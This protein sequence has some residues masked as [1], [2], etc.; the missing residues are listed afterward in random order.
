MSAR[1]SAQDGR[2][3]AVKP[4]AH[5]PR[6]RDSFNPVS[7]TLDSYLNETQEQT[8]ASG[9]KN[10]PNDTILPLDS[11]RF[12]PSPHEEPL[13]PKGDCLINISTPPL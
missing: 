11:D 1:A 3:L 2:R 4:Y 10:S 6:S 7:Y 8:R 12:G 9:G 13:L 5:P